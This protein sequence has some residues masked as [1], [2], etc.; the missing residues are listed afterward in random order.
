MAPYFQ[1]VKS[2]ADVPFTG[3]DGQGGVETEAFLAA[4][5][6]LVQLFDLLGSGVFGFVQADIRGNINGVR[7]RY[8]SHKDASRTL[9]ELVQSEKNEPHRHAT[10]CLVRLIRGLLFTCR[11]LQHMQRD[12]SCELHV[13]FRRAYDEVLRHHHNFVIRGVVGV[14]IRATPHR[15]A[16]YTSIAQGEPFDELDVELARWLEGLDRIVGSVRAFL[17]S[18]GF[19]KV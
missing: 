19:G 1:T 8:D 13:C 17:E 4:S 16:F 5:D 10:P 2:F 9:E 12:T 3:E 11:A 18:G 7:A 6:G 14:A 15:H